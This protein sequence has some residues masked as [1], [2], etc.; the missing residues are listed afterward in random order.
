MLG[1]QSRESIT[2]I[3]IRAAEP[4]DCRFLFN[5]R[6]HPDV[7]QAS[8][9]TAEI[10]YAG[11]EKWFE[12]SLSDPQRLIY[13]GIADGKRVG[14]VR[15]DTGN[16]VG[17]V[18]IAVM[19]GQQKKGIGTKMLSQS[20]SMYLKNNTCYAVSA[21]IKKSNIPSIKAFSRAGF[22]LYKDGNEIEM[23]KYPTHSFSI[24]LKIY[25]SN[26]VAFP[27]LLELLEKKVIDY[28]E[29]YIV[30]GADAQHLTVFRGLPL[31]LHA[32]NYNHGFSLT[33]PNENAYRAIDDAMQV[34][35]QPEIIFHP[36][37][38]SDAD[39]TVEALI[40]VLKN[41]KYRVI[42]ENVPKK[43]YKEGVELLIH[44]PYEYEQVISE[45]GVKFCLD[46]GHAI[47]AANSERKNHMDF[48]R[49]FLRLGPYMYHLSDSLTDDEID[50]HLNLLD[51]NLPL[52]ELVRLIPAN[53]KVSLET[54]KKDFVNL[55][56]DLQN[57]DTFLRIS[58]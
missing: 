28:V 36:G 46:I 56:E 52:A 23:R 42:L 2:M 13:I 25:S 55:L 35:G 27:K 30:P 31:I 44:T 5:L 3:E 32:P 33:K 10:K 19:P 18:S 45:T 8:F 51:G 50:S 6:N 17:V 1:L 4:K 58:R 47:A 54:P 9:D 12:N 21:K 40:E 53:A 37:Y 11:H 43:G 7:R 20:C 38:I 22:V 24:G 29:I 39:D 26:T 49:E 48:V 15:F 34:L 41:S 14:M 16:D 57:I